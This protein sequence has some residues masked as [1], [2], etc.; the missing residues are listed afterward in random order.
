MTG[1]LTRL[2][3]DGL[4]R[5][6]KSSEDQ[7]RVLVALTERGQQCFVSMSD[8]MEGNY[9]RIEEQFGAEKMQ[10]LL[11]LLNEFKNIKP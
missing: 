8:G 1:V 5:R 3:R 10:Q 4:V 7:R 6:H 2:E 9:L 11:A